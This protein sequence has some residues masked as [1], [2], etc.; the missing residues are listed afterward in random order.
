MS[1]FVNRKK[2]S[3]ELPKGC[4]DLADVLKLKQQKKVSEF[5]NID[6]ARCDYCGGRAVWGTSFLSR[7]VLTEN[8]RCQQCCNDWSEFYAQPDNALPENWDSED[9]EAVKRIED[10]ERRA[11]EYVRRKVAERSKAP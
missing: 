5:R 6:N 8:W 7:R 10:L 2:R 1:E 11:E 9:Q 3:I 4:K